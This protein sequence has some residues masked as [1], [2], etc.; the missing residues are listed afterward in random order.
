MRDSTA[1]L[2]RNVGVAGDPRWELVERIV[3]S[4]CFVKSP[5]LCSFLIY[6]CDLFLRGR[7]DEINELNIGEALFDRPANYDPSVDG[8]VRSQPSRLR[9]PLTQYFRKEAAQEP[10]RLLIPKGGYMPVF[11]PHS[12]SSP[13]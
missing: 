12:L 10:I 8:L 1:Q 6:I 2:E 5:R 4:Q 9:Q 11:E 7:A 13:P 3:A